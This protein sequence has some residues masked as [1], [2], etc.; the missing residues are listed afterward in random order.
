MIK[1]PYIYI[2]G[3]RYIIDSIYKPE[4]LSVNIIAS[5]AAECENENDHDFIIETL[6]EISNTPETLMKDSKIIAQAFIDYNISNGNNTES[7]ILTDHDKFARQLRK[8]YK[9]GESWH[10]IINVLIWA[11]ND[12]FWTNIVPQHLHRLSNKVSTDAPSFYYKV[13]QA[14]IKSCPGKGN[15]DI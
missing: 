2:D 9:S 11:M 6:S 8:I 5:Y 13:K 10:E 14:M 1:N 15:Y 7:F 12:K 4:P 3:I